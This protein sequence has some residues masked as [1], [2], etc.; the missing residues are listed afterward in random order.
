MEESAR[1]RTVTAPPDG[2]IRNRMRYLQAGDR[3]LVALE[4]NHDVIR[5]LVQQAGFECS[6]EETS[7]QFVLEVKPA[8]EGESILLFDA[9]E[10]SNLGWFSRC[11][12]YINGLTGW[13]LQT[14]LAVANCRDAAGRIDAGRLRVALS[15][16]LPAGFRLPGRQAVSEQ[17][18]YALLYNL[19]T[20]LRETGVA[21]CGKGS[22]EPL[23]GPPRRMDSRRGRQ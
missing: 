19:L 20:A 2:R 18:V 16:E 15:T 22:V 7:R 1:R 3:Q 11:Q 9:A 17:V 4:P 6:I 5:N 13:V 14:P 8:A 21:V 23:V 10:P 12:F